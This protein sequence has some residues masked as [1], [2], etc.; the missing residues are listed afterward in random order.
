MCKIAPGYNTIYHCGYTEEI[1][2][3][4]STKE[5]ATTSKA[6]SVAAADKMEPFHHRLQVPYIRSCLC[7]YTSPTAYIFYQ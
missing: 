4:I 1:K 7:V 3:K 5:V 2:S 6:T